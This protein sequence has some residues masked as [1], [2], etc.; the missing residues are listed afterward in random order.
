MFFS[1]FISGCLSICLYCTSRDRYKPVQI[2]TSYTGPSHW[3][4]EPRTKIAGRS[5]PAILVLGS[6]GPV[7]T[8]TD[9]YRFVPLSI[10]SQHTGRYKPVQ[11]GTSCTSPIEPRTK[12]QDCRARPPCNLGSWLYNLYRFV[13]ACTGPC[14][15]TGE[16]F[17]GL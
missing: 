8:C 12:N 2:G 15:S 7:Q 16:G 13:P 11:I 5:C 4:Q 3:N 10:L 1:F 17:Q 6:M 14:V 9:L